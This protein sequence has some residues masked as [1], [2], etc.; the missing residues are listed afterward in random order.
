MRISAKSIA[1][2]TLPD[3]KSDVIHFDADLPGFGYRLRRSP[4]GQV[5]ASWIAQY[6]RA[7]SSRRVLL[8]AGGVLS[9]EQARAAARKILSQAALGEDPQGDKAKR[10]DRDRLSLRSVVDEYIAVKQGEVRS[11]TLR[12][13][14]R[15]LTGAYF[16]LLHAMPVDSITRKDV[17]SQIL[18]VQRQHSATVAALAR[19]ALG[20]FFTWT[21][22]MGLTESNPVLG[23]AQP[24][25][26]PA[27]ERVLNDAELASIWNACQ[28]DD[29][30]KIIRLLILTGCRRAEVGGMC[31]SEIDSERGTWTI[32]KERS[33]NG[34]AHSLPLMPAALDILGTVPRLAS[35]DHLFG[36]RSSAGFC[37]WAEGKRALDA[38]SGVTGW[39]VHDL[40]RSTATK[41]A[42]I[43]IAPHVIEQILNHQSGHRSGVAGVYNRSSYEREVRAALALWSDH[44]RSLADG[45]ERKILPMISVP[46]RD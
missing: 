7:G 46:S 10:R 45:G 4:S 18:A 40:R 31:W 20:A 9:A 25:I 19:T 3:G 33:K 14:T 41:L 38:R 23:S 6:R 13:L 24:K 39:V 17:A 1:A 8:G 37:T 34:R 16:K 28:D 30:G 12:E 26:A 44:M 43:G 32:P 5:N 27:R 2:L 36:A 29:H 35:R 22:T 11:G 21:M 42:D 15:Y